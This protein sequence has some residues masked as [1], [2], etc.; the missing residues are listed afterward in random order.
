MTTAQVLEK[1]NIPGKLFSCEPLGSGN[2]NNTYI[3]KFEFGG[4]VL[5]YVLQRVNDNVFSD[6][7]ALMSNV[8]CVTD[9]LSKKFSSDSS[10]NTDTLHFVPT[11][12]GEYYFK[13][14]SGYWRVSEY[15]PNT[16]AYNTT[17]DCN[18]IYKCGEAFGKFQKLLSDFPVSNLN[19][20]I[21]DFHTTS[22][23]FEKFSESCAKDVVGRVRESET[24]INIALAEI[25]HC[26]SVLNWIDSLG[27]PQRVTHNDT[28]LNNVLFDKDSGECVCVIDLD[29]VMPGFVG[30]DFGDAIRSCGNTAF[31]SEKDL[32]KVTLS[33]PK[34]EAFAKGFL[35]QVKD[36]LIESEVDSLASFCYTITL[37]CGVRFLTDYLLGDTYFTVRY[38]GENLDRAR[39]QFALARDIRSKLDFLNIIIK[40]IVEN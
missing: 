12:T 26:K 22:K 28:K 2:I 39:V 31:E 20:T 24:D 7:P 35:S 21:K 23:Y 37:E 17:E 40:S 14:D 25:E 34:F 16:V 9:Y 6:V 29:T 30:S 33:L 10:D 38:P 5:H 19:T 11:G 13:D 1:F 18:L 32:S 4:D 15:V 8:I 27:L 36:A 3:A